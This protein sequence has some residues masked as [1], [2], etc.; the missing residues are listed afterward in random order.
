MNLFRLHE[1]V[2]APGRGTAICRRSVTIF[3]SSCVRQSLFPNSLS[4]AK[5]CR[6]HEPLC[7]R[8]WYRD[9]QETCR[10]SI[11]VRV[12]VTLFSSFLVATHI[13]VLARDTHTT[14]T[15][16]LC[17]PR[18]TPVQHQVCLDVSRVVDPGSTKNS[19]CRFSLCFSMFVFPVEWAPGGVPTLT[20]G[21]T[22]A[23]AGGRDALSPPAMTRM[24]WQRVKWATPA[25]ADE[26]CLNGS[27]PDLQL[28]KKKQL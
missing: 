9:F 13:A 26:K 21:S 1:T 19:K 20:K 8:A 27:P 16:F 6:E 15:P 3:Q 2:H 10:L 4:A 17:R 7:R 25:F 11:N 14:R 22:I 5:R 28:S 18:C 23:R 24:R 12:R